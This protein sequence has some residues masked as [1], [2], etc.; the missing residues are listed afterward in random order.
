M[1]ADADAKTILTAL[2]SAEME[3]RMMR[4]LAPQLI[5]PD[6]QLL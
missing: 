3:Q 4:V 1:I 2:Q 5:I 6:R